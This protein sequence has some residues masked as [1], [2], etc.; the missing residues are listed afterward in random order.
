M[1]GL[2]RK[3]TALFWVLLAPHSKPESHK[4][5]AH[6]QRIGSTK[7]A[8][9]SLPNACLPS[10]L[11][12]EG[13]FL[14]GPQRNHT[15]SFFGCGSCNTQ[16]NKLKWKRLERLMGQIQ[17]ERLLTIWWKRCF[18]LFAD[19]CECTGEGI[20]AEPR[21]TGGECSPRV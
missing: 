10:I 1:P 4:L 17:E 14:P 19:E 18:S 2:E 21:R 5:L 7:T 3:H 15:A 6:S 16:N 9:H 8:V 12:S 11:H 20:S 13:P